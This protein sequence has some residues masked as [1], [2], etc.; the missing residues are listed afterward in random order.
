VAYQILSRQDAKKYLQEL[1]ADSETKLSGV[2]IRE[3][4]VEQDWDEVALS[5]KTP[6]D[7]LKEDIGNIDKEDGSKKFERLAAKIVHETLPKHVALADPEFWTWLTVQHFVPL[8]QWRY[9]GSKNLQNYGV[10]AA[11]ENLLFRLW[12]RG[13]IGNLPGA[14][15]P[16]AL[17]DYGDIDFWR[18]HLFRQGYADARN[19]AHAL[20]RFQ[21]PEKL[22]GTAR[23]KIS[24]IRELVKRLKN[25]RTNLVVELMDEDRAFQFIESEWSKL[26]AA[27]K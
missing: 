9:P 1:E 21:F 5:I 12:L 14:K 24:E 15:T 23:L 4:G 6:L 26:A 3:L 8:V 13:D 18:S 17:I 20:I 10:G 19:F 22:T 27:T 2:K 7:K 16:Y 25:A 11:V